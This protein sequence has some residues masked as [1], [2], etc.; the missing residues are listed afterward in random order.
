MKPIYW[1]LFF[2]TVLLGGVFNL[3][4]V[5]EKEA[6]KEEARA[7]DPAYSNATV[8][9]CA[10]FLNLRKASGH[11]EAIIPERCDPQPQESIEQLRKEVA[12]HEVSAYTEET[13]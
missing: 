11:P 10:P 2:F 7:A 8:R 9:Y 5:A 12:D 3:W 13:Q 4:Q 1:Y 6:E